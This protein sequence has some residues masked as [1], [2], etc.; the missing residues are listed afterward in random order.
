MKRVIAAIGVFFL[1][2][3]AMNVGA[4]PVTTDG[5]DVPDE[6]AVQ[7]FRKGDRAFSVGAEAGGAGAVLNATE[8]L[9]PS[10]GGEPIP[11]S[12]CAMN[13]ET[14]SGS[15]IAYLGYFCKPGDCSDFKFC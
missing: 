3:V 11:N 4:A 6:G 14:C 15:C 5:W 7:M 12:R 2:A 8:Q 10:P 13:V 9:R 1:L